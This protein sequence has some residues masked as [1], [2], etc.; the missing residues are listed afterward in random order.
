M[1]NQIHPGAEASA[2]LP[3]V[4]NH[5]VAIADEH[6][7]FSDFELTDPVPTGR[8]IIEAYSSGDAVEF[9]VL[10]WFPNGALEELHLDE[11]TD[12]RAT[13][14]ERFIVARSDR[15]FR[16]EVEGRRHEWPC[17]AITGA[18]IKQLAGVDVDDFDVYLA[19][20]DEPDLE[21]DDH[22]AAN[23]SLA[24]VER[25]SLRPRP[26]EIE[27]F[28]NN[29]TV[30]IARG[31]HTGLEIKEAAIAQGVPI[32]TDFVLSIEKPNGDTKVI[33]NSDQVR[34]HRRDRFIA[35]AD[36]DNS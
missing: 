10:Q 23:L 34:V 15:T 2:N 20:R 36:D 11:E 29:R 26:R 22:D 33:G 19:R 13:G 31:L 6:L 1:Q 35:I 17:A 8:Q 30:K 18:T 12:L 27:I 16:F 25:F 9:I 3:P 28:V 14:I 24:G 7:S 5:R 4:A 21:L 32:Q